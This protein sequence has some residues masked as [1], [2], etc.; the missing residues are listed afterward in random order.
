METMWRE[1][2]EASAVRGSF[3]IERRSVYKPQMCSA[4]EANPPAI[5]LT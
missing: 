4:I 3:D 1:L 5:S 2:N